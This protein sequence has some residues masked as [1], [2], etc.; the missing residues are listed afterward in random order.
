MYLKVSLTLCYHNR[1]I[2]CIS[3]LLNG[4]RTAGVEFV[5]SVMNGWISANQ[6]KS[7]SK[8]FCTQLSPLG[9]YT[10][11]L[12]LSN[13]PCTTLFRRANIDVFTTMEFSTYPP[14]EIVLLLHYTGRYFELI[15]SNFVTFYSFYSLFKLRTGTNLILFYTLFRERCSCFMLLLVKKIPTLIF[16]KKY[17]SS[18]LLTIFVVI[19][20]KYSLNIVSILSLLY[21]VCYL[22]YIG[23]CVKY[24]ITP[25]YNVMYVTNIG[26]NGLYYIE[27]LM[28][29][30][31]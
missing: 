17:F 6:L 20:F 14:P 16:L 12:L 15:L 3:F 19:I 4:L 18:V 10:H 23:Y 1:I 11:L 22:N 31:I 7:V 26:V 25:H 27:L 5:H 21:G 30:F 13:I 2:I 28:Y 29:I 24:Y 9:H 8:L